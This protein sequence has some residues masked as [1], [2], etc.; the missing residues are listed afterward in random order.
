[1][2]ALQ[3]MIDADVK[4][5]LPDLRTHRQ[6]QAD[7]LVELARR[8]LDS[9]E[10]PQVGGERPHVTVTVGLD[11]L[12]GMEEGTAELDHG[13]VVHTDTA[14]RLACDSSVRRI[15]LGPSSEPLDVGRKTPVVPAAM[16]RAVIAR[17]NTC[18]LGGC[19]RPPSWCDV[20]HI[21][22]W[23]DG[24][25][26]SL[27]NCVLLCR[28]HHHLIHEEGFSVEMTDHGPLFRRPD[29]SMIE[30]NRAPP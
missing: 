26:T 7:A 28:R 19:G 1:M 10:R 9:P 15:V 17:D 27:S 21:R 2:T 14:R 30:G 18:R 24:G 5:G 8:Y 20:H 25:A 3:A 11:V 12:R 4:S 16:S 23:A 6:R 22:H 13:S 29:G